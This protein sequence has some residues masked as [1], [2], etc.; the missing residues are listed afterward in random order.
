MA[1]HKPQNVDDED[2]I[3]GEEI[4]GKPLD[5]PTS[6]SYFLERI[7]FGEIFRAS[8][9]RSQLAALS[10]D[11]ISFQLVQEMETRISR[12]WDDAP[13]AEYIFPIWLAAKQASHT[14]PPVQ[15]V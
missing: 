6:M 3:D 4:V 15:P 9:E 5:Q 12:F 13:D 7:R 11:T 14:Q 2:C 10:P 1:V 8:L